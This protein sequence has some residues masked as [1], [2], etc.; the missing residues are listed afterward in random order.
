MGSAAPRGGTTHQTSGGGPIFV[1]TSGPK[2]I[3]TAIPY[4]REIV[5]HY[6]WHALYGRRVPRLYAERRSG[7]D[8]AMVEA[9]TDVAI[10]PAALVQILSDR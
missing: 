6:R 9:V 8:V 1:S 3:V 7:L 10:V 5:V 2:L 4:R